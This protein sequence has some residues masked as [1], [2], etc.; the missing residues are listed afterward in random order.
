M[1]FQVFMVV[2][3]KNAVFWDVRWCSL[4]ECM[5]SGYSREV[6]C[7]CIL[8]GFYAT[9]SGNFLLT[10]RTT[11]RSCKWD[12]V[13][14]LLLLVI[15]Y[16]HFG[17][18]IGPISGMLLRNYRYSLRNNPE[19]WSSLLVWYKLMDPSEEPAASIFRVFCPK[20]KSNGFL[21]YVGK[22]LPDCLTLH[23]TAHCCTI[24]IRFKINTI[25][26]FWWWHHNFYPIISENELASSS[27]WIS[28]V[29]REFPIRSNFL[30]KGV[31]KWMSQWNQGHS[32]DTSSVLWCS[33]CYFTSVVCFSSRPDC[34]LC[35]SVLLS[36]V[37]LPCILFKLEDGCY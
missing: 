6:D 27:T 5:I 8:L 26:H 28:T 18:P 10:F 13:K 11:S 25:F 14:K 7:N 3:V 22:F 1:R 15:S 12:V 29:N 17:Q 9:S 24:S 33:L 23:L 37:V 20:D 4:V 19:E 2:S 16:W 31:V 21:Q 36:L 30:G 35:R 34:A 32:S